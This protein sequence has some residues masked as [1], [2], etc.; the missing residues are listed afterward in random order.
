MS[1]RKALAGPTL[2]CLCAAVV[3]S[4][5]PFAAAQTET[6]LYRFQPINDVQQPY[7]PMVADA[8]GNLYGTTYEG[9][10]T[11]CDNGQC[12]GGVFR[13][14]P[15]ASE[16]AS[17]TETVLYMFGSNPNDGG[18]PVAGMIFDKQGNLYGTTTGGGV[19][20][21]GIVFEL[22]P[23]T[24]GSTAWTET[25][26]YNFGAAGTY[27]GRIPWAAVVFDSKGNLYGTTL[28]G[29]DGF[30]NGYPGCGTAFELTP[31]T[32]Q[33]VAWKHRTIHSFGSN[34]DGAGPTAPLIVTSDGVLYGTTN[35]GGI[36][37][38]ALDDMPEGCAVVF[39]LTPPSSP[40]GRWS[41]AYWAIPSEAT[42][43]LF[44]G[45]LLQG[46]DGAL[47]APFFAGGTGQN[48]QDNQGF[49]IGCGGVY[50]LSPPAAGGH[51][52]KVQTIYTLTGLSDGAFPVSSLISD[53]AGN[54]YGT[55]LGG[56][57]AG[58]CRG[59]I[60]V[61]SNGC[62]SAFK[63]TPPTTAEGAWT[64]TTLHDF[65]GG[66]DGQYPWSSMILH[67]GVLFGTTLDGGYNNGF[68]GLGT[69]YSIVP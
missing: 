7:S 28:E 29:G 53:G 8:Q 17:W 52:W 56:G 36:W 48:C 4:L 15:P 37:N 42:G 57:G 22:S 11:T 6:V 21:N 16:G 27:D 2:L 63:L 14:S 3:I 41:E 66:S 47:Y 20:G 68:G 54:L 43:A 65:A 39:Q 25:I 62:G 40:G 59:E 49:P 45:G 46:R 13:L 9:G 31:P 26:L 12:N 19:Y 51:Q 23:P 18:W 44:Y 33:G 34:S 60:I 38:C 10:I 64:E 50:K 5:A 55:A 61:W 67:N 69:I 30:C 58:V 24:G 35:G 1:R 32:T